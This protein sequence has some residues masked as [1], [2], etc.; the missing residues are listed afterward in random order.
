MG[1]AEHLKG[2]GWG[3]GALTGTFGSLAGSTNYYIYAT[4][5]DIYGGANSTNDSGSTTTATTGTVTVHYT[6]TTYNW[7]AEENAF[8]EQT[9]TFIVT[10]NTFSQVSGWEVP[11][12][13]TSY[14]T[15]GL[16][17]GTYRVTGVTVRA[18]VVI[19]GINITSSSRYFHV[20]WS[21][22]Q[23]SYGSASD[24]YNALQAPFSTNSGTA[25]QSE[26]AGFTLQYDNGGGGRI[27]VRGAGS[28]GTYSTSPDQRIRV[29]M[30]I[31]MKK[32]VWTQTNTPASYTY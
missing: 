16:G 31:A 9:G 1:S 17:D 4:S 26:G 30:T 6:I 27:R 32:K 11:G 29:Q 25:I 28:V 20:D 18:W 23:T 13:R 14:G 22:A 5:T 8:D 7:G 3:S 19:S 24:T 21:G 10:G 12:Y 2:G 15:P